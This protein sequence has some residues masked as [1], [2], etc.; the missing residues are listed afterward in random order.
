M[1]EKRM[2]PVDLGS[3]RNNYDFFHVTGGY[4]KGLIDDIIFDPTN[5][6]TKHTKGIQRYSQR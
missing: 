5:Q 2:G 6:I 1:N 3:D 4:C